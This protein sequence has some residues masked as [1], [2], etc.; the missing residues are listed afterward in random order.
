MFWFVRRPHNNPSGWFSGKCVLIEVLEAPIS[1]IQCILGFQA[2]IAVCNANR[3]FRHY[4][5][6]W[7]L[8]THKGRKT[9]SEFISSLLYVLVRFFS[10]AI[11][12]IC[13]LKPYNQPF[14]K[15]S[16]D[17]VPFGPSSLGHRGRHG[18][19]SSSFN[20]S[21]NPLDAIISLVVWV[22]DPVLADCCP[23][24]THP[25]FVQ[26]LKETLWKLEMNQTTLF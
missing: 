21:N 18:P 5:Q 7:Y 4:L 11:L 3:H 25:T 6:D 24:S 8:Q 19:S 12:L 10:T 15:I 13:F 16:S 23:I 22:S 1:S 9:K 26:I 17:F 20:T 2:T 14:S